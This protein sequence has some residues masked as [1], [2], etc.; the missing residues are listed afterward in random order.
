MREPQWSR[1]V[2]SHGCEVHTSPLKSLSR[3]ESWLRV[4]RLLVVQ[5][6]GQLPRSPS[7]CRVT[8]GDHVIVP[9]GV[10]ASPRTVPCRTLV[11]PRG[12]LASPRMVQSHV[13]MLCGVLASP[14][15]RQ[16]QCDQVQTVLTESRLAQTVLTRNCWFWGQCPICSIQT[17]LTESFQF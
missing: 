3:L 8:C 9:H 7:Q 13:C 14:R 15:I 17:V 11:L 12:V 2:H 1:S 4:R 5:F 6:W 10:L 16:G